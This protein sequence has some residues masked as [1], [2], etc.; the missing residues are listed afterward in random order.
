MN[1][2]ILNVMTQ[3]ESPLNIPA[4]FLA[5]MIVN[6][7]N[8]TYFISNSETKEAIIVDPMREDLDATLFELQNIKDYRLIVI[9]THTHA[10]HVSSASIIASEFK[11]PLVMSAFA[12]SSRIDIKI[13][14]DTFLPMVAAP[15]EFYITQGHTNDCMTIRWGVFLLTGDTLMYGDTGRDDLPGGDPEKHYESVHKILKFAHKNDVFLPGH[16]AEARVSTWGHQLEI[17]PML[18]LS[19]E[20]FVKE[21]GAWVGPSPKNLKESLFE[22]LK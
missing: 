8:L 19:R 9:D 14:R 16:D 10:D 7:D 4:G 11:A 2:R 18:R 3:S 17:N 15:L 21:A 1:T 13:N 6:E 5:K 22:N 20:A 12:P